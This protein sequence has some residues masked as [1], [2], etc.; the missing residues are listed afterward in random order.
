MYPVLTS[1]PGAAKGDELVFPWGQPGRV[2]RPGAP[3]RRPLNPLSPEHTG[4]G[5]AV[6]TTPLPGLQEHGCYFP[7]ER[8]LLPVPILLY[9]QAWQ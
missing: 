4:K 5:R 2:G 3:A 6:P 1:W 8:D 7:R 9:G